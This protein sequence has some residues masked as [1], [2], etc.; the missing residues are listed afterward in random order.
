MEQPC[1]KCGQAVEEGVPFCPHCSAPQIRVVVAEAAQGVAVQADGAYAG[2]GA[3]P[4]SRTVPVLALPMEWSQVVKPCALAALIAAVAMVL[5]LMVPLIAVLGAG[6]L[7]VAF[8]RRNHPH[9]AVRAGSG[10]RLGAVCGVFC[11]G[12]TAILGAL[13][14]AILHEG[15]AIRNWILDQVRQTAV[16]FPGPQSQPGLE[17]MRSPVGLMFM[18]AFLLVAGA[19]L[20]V[21]L[22]TLGGALGGALLGRRDKN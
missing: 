19:V 1:H 10:A 2:S 17:F 6:F 9:V 12:M 7:A 3:L 18:L 11:S 8:Y 15:N 22:S 14:V 5:G 16:R 13:R 4:A 20:L 21:L